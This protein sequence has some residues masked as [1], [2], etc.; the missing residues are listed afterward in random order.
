MR[1]APQYTKGATLNIAFQ[2]LGL[3]IAIGMTVYY[4][5]ENKK[6]DEAEGG[7]PPKGDRLDFGDRYDLVHGFRYV[8]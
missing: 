3:L 8:I 7:R 4:R 5:M 2:V 1:S 6:R